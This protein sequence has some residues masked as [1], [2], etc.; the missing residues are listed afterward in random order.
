MAFQYEKINPEV[1]DILKKI[2]E[3]PTTEWTDRE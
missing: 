3:K 1:C 2:C